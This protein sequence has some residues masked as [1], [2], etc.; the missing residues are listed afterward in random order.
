VINVIL[1]EQRLGLI[2]GYLKDLKRLAS[3]PRDEFLSDS[4]KVAAAESF[5][6]RSL[7]AVFDVGR[8]VLAKSGFIELAAEYKSIARG[9]A[10]RRFIDQDL[11]KALVEMA[12]YR[13]RLVHLYSEIAG[14]E[15]YSI[16]A[17]RLD[18]IGEF[19]RQIRASA[20]AGE[21]Q[22]KPPLSGT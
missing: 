14:D 18:D 11:G 3:L 8:H 21:S 16:I 1:V 22:T 5:L 7:E 2:S 9:L 6:R 10:D 12:G 19:V 17:G 13:D 4:L 15:L 20:C